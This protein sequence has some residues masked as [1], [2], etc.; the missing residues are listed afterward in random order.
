VSDAFELLL[1]M[2]LGDDLT[3][4]EVDELRWHL[5]L[6]PR[7]PRLT[8]VP[9]FPDVLVDDD[10]LPQV[11]DAPRPL[12]AGAG[13]AHHRGVGGA[14]VSALARRERPAGW[15][16]TTRQELH[17]DDFGLVRALLDRLAQHHVPGF[18]GSYGHPIGHLRF[19]E[20]I[21]PSPLFLTA[22]GVTWPEQ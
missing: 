9:E 17:P 1:A 12:L 15:A 21:E 13:P 3:A 14:L 19:H 10:G 6:G 11:V 2:D 7:P 18:P 4:A 22:D 5:G 8:I 16:L 20:E